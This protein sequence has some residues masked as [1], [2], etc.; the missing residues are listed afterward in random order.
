[1]TG[2]ILRAIQR[3]LRSWLIVERNK[4]RWERLRGR[5]D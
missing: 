5:Y 1:M 4:R 3:A 2:R